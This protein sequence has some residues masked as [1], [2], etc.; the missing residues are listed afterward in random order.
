MKRGITISAVTVFM[1]LVVGVAG[2]VGR[3]EPGFHIGYQSKDGFKAGAFYTIDLGSGF[4]LQPEL[5]FSQRKYEFVHY[6]CYYEDGGLYSIPAWGEKDY[7]TVRFI[8]LP[9]LIKYRFNA[10]G[11][12]RPVLFAGGYA[13][14]RISSDYVE[15]RWYGIPYRKY[16]DIDA[17]LILGAGF[18]HKLGKIKMHYDFRYTV[19]LVDVQEAGTHHNYEIA[20]YCWE[21]QIRKTSSFAV[22]VGVSF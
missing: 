8:E 20:T 5:N 22:M 6:P 10:G 16:K 2:L 17:G 9:V 21:P 15:N 12:F 4:A 7:D 3:A 13:A 11:N 19:G 14:Y 1:M 18:E